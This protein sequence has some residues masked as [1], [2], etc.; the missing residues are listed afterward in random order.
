[1]QRTGRSYLGGSQSAT[2]ESRVYMYVCVCIF[3]LFSCWSGRRS[4]VGDWMILVVYLG[5]LVYVYSEEEEDKEGE[6]GR[7]G[8][9]VRRAWFFLGKHT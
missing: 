6:G 1:M 7:E 3:L 4:E 8:G 2:R 9:F 5:C